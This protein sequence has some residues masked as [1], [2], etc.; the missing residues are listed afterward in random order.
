[1]VGFGPAQLAVG[2]LFQQLGQALHINVGQRLS[3]GK[4]RQDLSRSGPKQI[5]KLGAILGKGQVQHAHQ[6]HFFSYGLLGALK[7]QPGQIAQGLHRLC[8]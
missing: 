3:G 7:A 6:A 1:M 2:R 8:Q 4:L 5:G